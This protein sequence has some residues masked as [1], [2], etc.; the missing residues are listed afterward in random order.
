MSFFFC[1]LGWHPQHVEVFRLGLKSELQL[2]A[3]TIATAMQDLSLIFDLHHSS[4]QGWILN[5]L[6]KA[7]NRTHIIM[8]TS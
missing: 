1:F 5:P 8:D 4:Q 6:I 3:Y 7:G 2:Q